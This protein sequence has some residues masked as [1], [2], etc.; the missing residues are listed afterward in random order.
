MQVSAKRLICAAF[1]V[2]NLASFG[3]NIYRSSVKVSKLEKEMCYLKETECNIKE[4][5]KSYDKEIEDIK[6]IANRE[7][8]V[9]NKLQMVKDGEII[10]RVTK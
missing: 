6:D 3:P 8:M 9:R 4:K 7:K 2:I 10:Y 5:I 1:V